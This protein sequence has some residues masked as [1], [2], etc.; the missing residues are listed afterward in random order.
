MEDGH[1]VREHVFRTGLVSIR[2]AEGPQS[3]PPLLL[4]HGFMARWQT[5]L[6][7]IAALSSRW[8]VYAL[9]FR[10]HGGSGRAPG[11]YRI[12][13]YTGDVIAFIEDKFVEPV[14]LL[15]HSMGGHIA[16]EVAVRVPAKVRALVVG[17]I[18]LH[19]ETGLKL[20]TEAFTRFHAALRELLSSQ[21]PPAETVSV[22]A[23]LRPDL[24]TV[25]L[26]A[27][28]KRLCL[29]DP[30]IL[31]YHAEGRLRELL[32]GMVDDAALRQ[33]P[34]PVLLLQGDPAHGGLT[35]D[36]YIERMLTV[37]PD[38][39]R[40]KIEGCGHDLGLSTW[41]VAPLLRAVTSFLES[42]P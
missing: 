41:Q 21:R 27:W 19:R 35:T 42:R 31:E 30:G 34:C 40:A 23:A 1:P 6:P 33:V 12:A 5:F 28:A 24:D 18:P 37:I 9:D 14:A 20:E 8:H 11:Q 32:E 7:V 29:L 38:A 10:G 25:A 13:D 15:G 39:C 3:G 4:L 36:A 16:V 26:R 2:Y 22:L 17:D